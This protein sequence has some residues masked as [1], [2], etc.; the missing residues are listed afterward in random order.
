MNATPTNGFVGQPNGYKA[1]WANPDAKAQDAIARESFVGEY[2]KKRWTTDHPLWNDDWWA[3]P[4]GRGLL[5]L[6][7]CKPNRELAISQLPATPLKP[8]AE[9]MMRFRRGCLDVLFTIGRKFDRLPEYWGVDCYGKP[10]PQFVDLW[11]DVAVEAAVRIAVGEWALDKVNFHCLTF[12]GKR[13]LLQEI[14]RADAVMWDRLAEERFRVAER[15]AD[16]DRR[17][18][19][20]EE[21]EREVENRET[22]GGP[23]GFNLDGVYSNLLE[24]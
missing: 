24:K 23:L 15:Q 9:A 3:S 14:D 5:W 18:K 22:R 21:R 16:L 13:F 12:H 8:T 20:L 4:A 11:K 1:R 6:V 10:A 2:L 7:L 17:E 19:M